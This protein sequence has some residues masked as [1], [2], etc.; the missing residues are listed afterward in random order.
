MSSELFL[1]DAKD[2][3]PDAQEVDHLR[4]AEERCDDQYARQGPGH[5]RSPALQPQDLLESVYNPAIALLV[6]LKL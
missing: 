3:L 6:R 4:H 5:Q 1:L 2:T